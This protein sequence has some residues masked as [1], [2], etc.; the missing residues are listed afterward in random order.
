MSEA[1]IHTQSLSVSYR[2][3][4]AITNVCLKIPRHKITGL[5]GA[6]GSGKS[7][8]LRSLNR[9]L[10]VIP[11]TK[12]TGRIL[13]NGS[14]ILGKNTDVISLRQKIG[15]VFQNPTPFPKSIYANV[16]FG[17]EV[18]GIG[19][20]Q[21]LSFL[22]NFF[23]GKINPESLESS[24]DPKDKLVVENLKRAA[25]WDEV[26]HRLHHSGL[27][28]SGGQQQ[29]L[30][31]AR[32]LAVQPEVILLDEPCSALD[33]ISTKKIEDLLLK[34]KKNYSIVIVTHNMHQA[35]R[36]CDHVGFFHLGKLI[37]FDTAKTI[38]EKPKKNLTR[39]YVGGAFG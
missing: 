13:F 25:L 2:S 16:A 35:R 6:S 30:C 12:V 23:S 14:D 32:S 27:S 28:L 19:K 37:E 36:I 39:R 24:R 22:S 31:I 20:K 15:M 26:K 17:L 33:P 21:R 8:F 38:F 29:R 4:P 34:L 11:Q 9:M 1:V 10:D 5:I 18:M 7:T 3:H